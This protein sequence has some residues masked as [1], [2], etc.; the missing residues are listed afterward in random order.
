[1][2]RR[3]YVLRTAAI[4]PAGAYAVHQARYG[5]GFGSGA[6]EALHHH[7]HGYLAAVAPLITLLLGAFIGQLLWAATRPARGGGPTVRFRRAW[8]LASVC[9]IG[10]YVAQEELEGLLTPGHPTG[11]AGVFGAGGW[12]AVP[13]ALLIG[14]LV[15]LTLRSAHAVDCAAP[16]RISW[17]AQPRLR[18]PASVAVV[19]GPALRPIVS[20]LARRSAGRAPPAGR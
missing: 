19:I 13:V 6:A 10:V 9:L 2:T 14:A 4:L 16:P 7:G 12:T 18:A 15:A 3:A 11:L 1:M 8:L 20:P 5:L 17:T